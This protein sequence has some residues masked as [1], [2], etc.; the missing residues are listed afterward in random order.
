MGKLKQREGLGN[1]FKVIQLE[2]LCWK[3]NPGNWFQSP[4]REER[5][6]AS[7]SCYIFKL[8]SNSV[9]WLIPP[10]AGI[11]V[12][13]YHHAWLR[14]YSFKSFFILHC[15]MP[16][17]RVYFQKL[18]F[19]FYIKYIT[20]KIIISRISQIQ[21]YLTWLRIRWSWEATVLMVTG[22]FTGEE[23][24]EIWTTPGGRRG[25]KE[26]QNSFLEPWTV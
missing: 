8:A 3:W 16:I 13:T 5:W 23:S 14:V 10:S 22:Q 9:L 1:L 2:A 17:P 25:R 21:E 6:S 7:E 12:N 15:L 26:K 20:K 24:I 18:I 19:Y 4:F 11:Q